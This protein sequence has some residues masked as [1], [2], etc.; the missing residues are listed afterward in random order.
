MVSSAAWCRKWAHRHLYRLV[1]WGRQAEIVAS[2]ALRR[3][4]PSAAKEN[5]VQMVRC[6]LVLP[7]VTATPVHPQDEVQA[8]QPHAPRAKTASISSAASAFKPRSVQVLVAPPKALETLAKR[9]PLHRRQ[10]HQAKSAAAAA[11]AT[12]VQ[13][14]KEK[15]R[16][17]ARRARV[18]ATATRAITLQAGTKRTV[19]AVCARMVL[20]FTA[21]SACLPPNAMQPAAQRKAGACTAGPAQASRG[22]QCRMSRRSSALAR[23]TQ[24]AG[25]A[26][27]ATT[28]TAA[29]LDVTRRTG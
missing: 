23:R 19:A 25:P 4:V 15:R 16:A 27:A 7:S 26:G 24:M 14:A 13:N 3:A 21:G 8:I 9:A 12:G 10:R 17:M 2:R 20:C 29:L 6:A 11:A 5:S 22:P 28:A 1:R 18:V